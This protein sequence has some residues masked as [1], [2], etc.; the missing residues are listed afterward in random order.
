[1]F[2]RAD[3]VCDADVYKISGVVALLPC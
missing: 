2:R 3:T 1:M